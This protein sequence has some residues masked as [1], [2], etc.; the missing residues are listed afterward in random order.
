[1]GSCSSAA[2][3]PCILEGRQRELDKDDLMLMKEKEKEYEK[4]VIPGREVIPSSR[5]VQ[6][7]GQSGSYSA[8]LRKTQP[9]GNFKSTTEDELVLVPDVVDDD[10]DTLQVVVEGAEHKDKG[11][12]L[13][14]A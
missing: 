12:Y 13:Y 5:I 3:C 2:L 9:T 14:F 7:E 6:V 10:E 8:Y 1:M 4:L 11:Q